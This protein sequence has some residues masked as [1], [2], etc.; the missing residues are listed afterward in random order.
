MPAERYPKSVPVYRIPRQLVFPDPRDASPEG[1]LGVGGDLRPER[2][3]LGYQ[4]GI[5][6]WYSEGQPIL[7]WSPDPRMVIDLDPA[8]PSFRVQRSLA[9]RVRQ[10]P[11][12]ITL[13]TAFEQ[14][15]AACAATPR[16]NQPG[17]W[18]T[19]EMRAAY[20]ALHRMGLAHSVEAWSGDTLVGGLYGVGVGRLFSGESMFAH[21]PDAS[22]IA[23]VHLVRQLERWGFL[24]ID[25]QVHTEHLARFGG[26]EIPRDDYLA[27]LPALLAEPGHSGSWAFDQYFICDG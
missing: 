22:K 18:L 20:V 10:R 12:R 2:L 25:C 27:R 1:L 8:Q 15:I 11:Y 3:L 9:K 14:V 24:L 17:T 7:W 5:F 21:A 13:D 6:P 19:D 4:M 26:I 23:F 16:P